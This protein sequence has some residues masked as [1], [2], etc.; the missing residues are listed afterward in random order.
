MAESPAGNYYN[1]Y[2]SNN[3]IV[4]SMMNGFLK[5]FDRLVEQA[6][7]D[8]ILEVGCG[9]GYLARRLAEQGYTVK[10]TDQSED[11][12]ADARRRTSNSLSVE[13]FYN[14]LPWSMGLCRCS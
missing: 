14:P 10:A 5:R 4:R 6:D 13:E 11:I 1:K 9:E 2:E 12:I 7:P 3:P 8:E